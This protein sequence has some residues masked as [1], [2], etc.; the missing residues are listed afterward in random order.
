MGVKTSGSVWLGRLKS[1]VSRLVKFSGV[2]TLIFLGA[3]AMAT[4][5]AEKATPLVGTPTDETQAVERTQRM[6][7][8]WGFGDQ[9]PSPRRGRLS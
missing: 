1:K 6:V 2:C 7:K 3:V 4:P 9:C 5:H 8:T